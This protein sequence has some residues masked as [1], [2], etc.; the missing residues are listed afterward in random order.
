MTTPMRLLV[1]LMLP[2]LP[3]LVLLQ[4][5]P[6]PLQMIQMMLGLEQ[7]NL[8]LQMKLIFHLVCLLQKD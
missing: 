1:G 5:T 4:I 3:L 6:I 2:V 8:L 7:F